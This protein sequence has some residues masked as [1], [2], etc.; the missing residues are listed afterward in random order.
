MQS[1]NVYTAR[2]LRNLSGELI[3]Q[4]EEG[5]LGLITKHGKPTLLTIPFD[6]SVLSFGVHRSLALNL[7]SS[8]QLTLAQA[9]KLAKMPME[10]FISLLGE[11]GIDAVDYSPDELESE[12]AHAAVL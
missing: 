3:Q 10:K 5:K 8:G 1:F 9:A 2:E 7:F 11:A 12:L 4:A 6:K